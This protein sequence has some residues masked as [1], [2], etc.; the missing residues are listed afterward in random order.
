MLSTGGGDLSSCPLLP[1][2]NHHAGTHLAGEQRTQ[3]QPATGSPVQAKNL[4]QSLLQRSPA[5][6]A[7]LPPAHST[8]SR[9]NR[10]K[11]P[12]HARHRLLGRCKPAAIPDG[13]AI[14]DASPG[15]WGLN[16]S[17]G[18]VCRAVGWALGWHCCFPGAPGPGWTLRHPDI[19]GRSEVGWGCR[20]V[21][22]Q[23]AGADFARHAGV[24]LQQRGFGVFSLFFLPPPPQ[25]LSPSQCGF[26]TRNGA[27]TWRISSI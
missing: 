4:T 11:A 2:P 9:E 17:L 7:L 12:I 10:C 26:M 18:W 3:L 23:D 20:A 5:L 27:F 13:F 15:R 16:V 1:K 6:A 14:A 19:A 8:E 22:A 24:K 21:T 25:R